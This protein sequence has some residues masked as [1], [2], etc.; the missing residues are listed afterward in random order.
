M[1]LDSFRN[2][3]MSCRLQVF[4]GECTRKEILRLSDLGLRD[5]CDCVIGVGG[6]KVMDTAKLV[7]VELKTPV[8][9]CP[10]IAA[11]DAPTAGRAVLYSEEGVSLQTL[12]LPKSPDVA[13][14]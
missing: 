5:R 8:M 13:L 9:I 1:I 12:Q 4:G 6:G 10:A 7:A 3:E 11:T 14:S 2:K